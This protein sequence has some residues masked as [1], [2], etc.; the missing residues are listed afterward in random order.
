[1]LNEWNETWSRYMGRV[2]DLEKYSNLNAEIARNL[3]NPGGTLY[4]RPNRS[5]GLD[6]LK[7]ICLHAGENGSIQIDDKFVTI[8]NQE[9]ER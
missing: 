2:G 9:P 3:L 4:I 1:M 6:V 5:P 7:L 8:K